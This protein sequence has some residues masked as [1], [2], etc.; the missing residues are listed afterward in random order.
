MTICVC[1]HDAYQNFM[2]IM[3]YFMT[4]CLHVMTKC[5]YFMT[6]CVHFMTIVHTSHMLYCGWETNHTMCIVQ[7]IAQAAEVWMRTAAK[8]MC[9]PEVCRN[10]GCETVLESLFFRDPNY[11]KLSSVPKHVNKLLTPFSHIITKD[12][13]NKSSHKR[14]TDLLKIMAML[15]E[16]LADKLED[17]PVLFDGPPFTAQEITACLGG[18]KTMSANA[19]DWF[20]GGWLQHQ[21]KD[22]MSRLTGA[23][24]LV[25]AD[26]DRLTVSKN[27]APYGR[28]ELR[29]EDEPAADKA[30]QD[31]PG[32]TATVSDDDEGSLESPSLG[33]QL[34]FMRC[35]R[36]TACLQCTNIYSAYLTGMAL[37]MWMLRHLSSYKGFFT[38][39]PAKR[40]DGVYTQE[41]VDAFVHKCVDTDATGVIMHEAGI[42][43]MWKDKSQKKEDPDA[44]LHRMSW[45]AERQMNMG[46]LTPHVLAVLDTRLFSAVMGG[47]NTAFGKGCG[48]DISSN[49]PE[50]IVKHDAY[51]KDRVMFH[52]RYNGHVPHLTH[53]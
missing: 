38:I 11:E 7:T 50:A 12:W 30:R 42:G 1:I 18:S 3:T 2:T 29:P 17:M 24:G 28:S 39:R 27:Y 48:P 16:L 37:I 15:G 23:G 4:K 32:S 33:A 5:V 22:G 40:A 47:V 43:N 13:G 45:C 53:A 9:K 51:L 21:V 31:S 35:V 34:R 14:D 36:H 20:D 44:I 26:E 6:K 46:Y 8:V 49:Q 19:R 25:L 10:F 41:E 52:Y